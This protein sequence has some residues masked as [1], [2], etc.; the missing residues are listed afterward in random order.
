MAE[1]HPTFPNPTIRE[2]LC[3]I[4]FLLP[5]DTPWDSSYFGAFFQSLQPSFPVFEPV[6]PT[7]LQIQ[8]TS[9]QAG[10]LPPESRMRYRHGQRN[11]LIQLSESILTVNVLP[12][13]EGWARM[14]ADVQWAWQRARN[15][16]QPSGITRIGLRYIN[17]VSKTGPNDV[18]SNWF[19]AND[20]VASA[21]L[22]SQPRAFSRI[23][24]WNGKSGRSVVTLAQSI[25]NDNFVLD[26]DC[27][28]E[29]QDDPLQ[30]PESTL[31]ALHDMAWRI[32]KGFITPQLRTLL[33]GGITHDLL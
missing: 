25:E 6:P 32:F 30:E 28:Q 19:A 17:F 27:I 29:S 13:Y 21:V 22:A 3:E 1:E 15:V 26:L 18:P 31:T 16:L 2:A 11:L 7:G 12:R 4:H 33:S 24:A 14:Q 20:Y 5:A 10:I 9:G 23:E 8:V